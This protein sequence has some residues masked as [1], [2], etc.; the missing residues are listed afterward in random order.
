MKSLYKITLF[1]NRQK[2][3][4]FRLESDKLFLSDYPNAMYE[5][6]AEYDTSLKGYTPME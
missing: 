5:V 2:I 3:I 4:V 6:F 1:K